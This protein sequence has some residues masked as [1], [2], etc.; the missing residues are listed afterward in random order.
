MTPGGTVY[1]P[2]QLNIESLYVAP[3]IGSRSPDTV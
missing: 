3:P 2:L 1:E